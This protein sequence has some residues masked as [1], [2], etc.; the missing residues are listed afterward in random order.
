ML[1]VFRGREGRSVAAVDGLGDEPSALGIPFILKV[2]EQT[3]LG[4]FGHGI[5]ESITKRVTH[6]IDV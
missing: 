3:Q 2:T 1:F 4:L 5:K 6:L